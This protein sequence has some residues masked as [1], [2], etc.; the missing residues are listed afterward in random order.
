MRYTIKCPYCGSFECSVAKALDGHQKAQESERIL[1]V[2]PFYKKPFF[3]HDAGSGG[4]CSFDELTDV[5]ACPGIIL[6]SLKDSCYVD[7]SVLE[8]PDTSKCPYEELLPEEL[9]KYL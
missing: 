1:P 9:R 2:S 8:E 4:L 6:P 3:I 7:I 5:V